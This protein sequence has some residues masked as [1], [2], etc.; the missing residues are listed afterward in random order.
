MVPLGQTQDIAATYWQVAPPVIKAQR[1][2]LAHSTNLLINFMDY[3][4]TINRSFEKRVMSF[5]DLIILFFLSFLASHKLSNAIN[6]E[7]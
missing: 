1:V 2:T 5:Y 7:F 4:Q 3:Q 6:S